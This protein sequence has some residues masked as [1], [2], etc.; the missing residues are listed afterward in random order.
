[1]LLAFVWRIFILNLADCLGIILKLNM[2]EVHSELPAQIILYPCKKKEP[3]FGFGSQWILSILIG[4][5][6][7]SFSFS[8]LSELPF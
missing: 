4:L 6:Y 2:Y 8:N 5:I 3:L 7:A 1:M